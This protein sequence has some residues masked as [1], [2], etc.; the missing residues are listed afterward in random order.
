M[1]C[2]TLAVSSSLSGLLAP[3]AVLLLGALLVK[4]YCY[5][6]LLPFWTHWGT[7][8]E[9]EGSA[10]YLWD[11]RRFSFILEAFHIQWLAERVSQYYFEADRIFGLLWDSDPCAQHWW[12]AWSYQF[13]RPEFWTERAGVERARSFYDGTSLI[14]NYRCKWTLP[15]QAPVSWSPSPKLS[16][17]VSSAHTRSWG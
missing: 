11:N 9:T 13:Q 3:S 8:W 10:S 7:Y 2:S 15:S 1:L 5:W 4:S 16:L 12:R 14:N 6:R 17:R